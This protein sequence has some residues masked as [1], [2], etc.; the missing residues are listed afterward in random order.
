MDVSIFYW[1]L[2][3]DPLS[4][5]VALLL[6]KDSIAVLVP[7]YQTRHKWIW[8]LWNK[9]LSQG[10]F[11]VLTTT[12]RLVI[13]TWFTFTV[14]TLLHIP[15]VL[16]W[17]L[18]LMWMNEF[19]MSSILSFCPIFTVRLSL[20]YSSVN[21]H[22]LPVSIINLGAPHTGIRWCCRLRFFRRI[23]TLSSM[24]V[25]ILLYNVHCM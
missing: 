6:P 17:I 13:F 12:V 3:S 9:T 5:R 1:T 18:R 19:D 4:H 10:T 11:S 24:S 14:G 21:K 15:P 20:F 8:T 7:F 23:H 22:G 2:R 25:S 16:F